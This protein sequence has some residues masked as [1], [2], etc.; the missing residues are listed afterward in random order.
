MIEVLFFG[1]LAD[2]TQTGRLLVERMVDTQVLLN[3]LY[4][5]Y[6]ALKGARFVV[7]VDNTVVRV[8]KPLYAGAQVALMPPF[9]GG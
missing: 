4:H 9:S 2:I 5:Q 1:R 6:P 7:A 3:Y 8:T